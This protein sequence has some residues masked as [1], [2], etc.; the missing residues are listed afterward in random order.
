MLLGLRVKQLWPS[1]CLLHLRVRCSVFSLESSPVFAQTD[2]QSVYFLT[3][4]SIYNILHLDGSV[5]AWLGIEVLVCCPCPEPSVT[6][7][8][9]VKCHFTFRVSFA[10]L[11]LEKTNSNLG[12]CFVNSWVFVPENLSD[13][14]FHF[15]D[16]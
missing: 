13:V 11:I 6:E 7:F 4:I 8:A 3:Y 16:I 14:F 9:P 15:R 10:L 1:L 12:L 5:I 2:S